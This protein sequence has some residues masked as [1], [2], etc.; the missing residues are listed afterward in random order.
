[1]R[2][3]FAA[4]ITA[5]AG[6]FSAALFPARIDPPDP[7]AL[8]SRDA[9]RLIVLITIDA[10]RADHLGIY[11]YSRPTSPYI[12]SF[13]RE[14]VVI[15]D[16]IAQAPYTKASVASLMT[17]LYPDAH[18]AFTVSTTVADV[19]DGHVGSALP[20][21]DILPASV[22]TLAEALKAHGY[23]TTAITTNPYLIADFGFSQGFDRFDFLA[24]DGF[25]TAEQALG[26]ALATITSEDR[27]HF[28]WVHLM[29][30]HS[31]YAPEEL[32]RRALPPLLPSRPIPSDVV[33]PSYLAERRSSDVRVYESL[34]DAEIRT[35]D[36]AVGCFLSALRARPAWLN[37]VVVLTADHGEE[38]LEHGGLEH[39]S[40]LYDELIRVPLLIRAPGLEP[41]YLDAQVQLVDV[42][43]TLVGLAGARVP[44]A[45]Q[46]RDLRP[47]LRGEA[48]PAQPALSARVGELYA[49]RTRE[50]KLIAGPDRRR[51]LYALAR[52][53]AEQHALAPPPRIA[54]MEQ[55]LESML[56]DAI[57]SGSAIASES[58][59]VSEDTRRR[60]E[61]LGYLQR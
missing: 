26:Q 42:L 9:P 7:P 61:A 37:T 56:A 25:A 49:V 55:M 17:G 40:T 52:D 48:V 46:G 1:M 2:L 34:Y 47:L 14:A 30:P 16:A 41:R 54:A 58:G 3:L 31:P 13:A 4:A 23:A 18:K 45:I 32:F 57:R 50:W 35:V 36:A 12:D 11:G 60:L 21:T 51:E 19:M 5:A 28:V 24:E 43:P 39:N 15:E 10:L 44:D 38:F 8:A 33:V 6:V 22:T 27:P 29:E 53:P 20:A 59:P